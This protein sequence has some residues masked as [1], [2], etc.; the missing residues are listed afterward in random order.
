[1]LTAPTQQRQLTE[2]QAAFVEALVTNGGNKTQAAITAGYSENTA[3]VQAY[4]LMRI[5]H[6][7]QAI[8]EAT[9][10]RMISDAPRAA[11]ALHKLLDGRSEYVRLEAA[12]EIL[13]RAGLKPAT[14]VNHR[15]A[16]DISVSIDLS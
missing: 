11:E 7:M 2:K 1:M 13:D 14:N 8:V 3:R 4:D 15:I 6:V 9:M 12:K 16:G 10:A 5:P